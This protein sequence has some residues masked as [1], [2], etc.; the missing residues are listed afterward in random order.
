MLNPFNIKFYVPRLGQ[1]LHPFTCIPI[2]AKNW[3][4]NPSLFYENFCDKKIIDRVQYRD[5]FPICC[6]SPIYITKKL[7]GLPL[8]FS[9]THSLSIFDKVK[10]FDYLIKN[11]NTNS[12]IPAIIHKWIYSPI[13]DKLSR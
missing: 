4:L 10:Y 7:V 9:Y 6:M 5:T 8:I 2:D 13:R 11:R 1:T 12:S 3:M